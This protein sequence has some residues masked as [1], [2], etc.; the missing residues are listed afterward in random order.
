MGYAARRKHYAEF[1]YIAILGSAIISY[2]YINICIY[3][4]GDVLIR[5]WKFTSFPE[6]DMSKASVPPVTFTKNEIFDHSVRDFL[7][8]Y[9]G[10]RQN[11]WFC[12]AHKLY[13]QCP[14]GIIDVMGDT[15]ILWASQYG[16]A[17]FRLQTM[18]ND[19]AC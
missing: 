18:L 12:S 2:F 17:M 16:A 4:E 11:S 10:K 9:T 19:R 6:T 15:S 13:L 14:S 8:E 1:F 7:L 3:K 5:K